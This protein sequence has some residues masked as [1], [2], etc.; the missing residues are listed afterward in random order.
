MRNKRQPLLSGPVAVQALRQ[1]FL[2]MNPLY[3]IKNPVNANLI[4]N[5]YWTFGRDHTSN[6]RVNPL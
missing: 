2:K 3:M 5:I 1:S 4:I 6:I